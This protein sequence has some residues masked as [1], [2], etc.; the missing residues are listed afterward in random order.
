VKILVAGGA[1][2]I[3]SHMTRALLDQGHEA[4][5]LDNLSSGRRDAVPAQVFLKGDLSQR[6]LLDTV[7]STRTF[8]CVLHFASCSPPA[9]TAAEPA[10]YYWNNVAYTLNL[11]D[12]M[13]KRQ[14]RRIVY[15]SSA[16]VY[17]EPRYVPVEETHPKNPL[18]PHGRSRWMVEQVL[19]DYERAHGLR[20]VSLRCFNAAGA[21]P[22]GAL[23]GYREP[24]TQLIP[25]AL[26]AAAGRARGVSIFGSDYDTPDGTCIR[27]YV[28]VAD[29][30]HAHLL[31]MEHLMEGG[32]SRA[33]NV[34]SGR[35]HSV[36]DVI[37]CAS[38]VSGTGI[39]VAD[40]GRREGD[41]E[42]LVADISLARRELGWQPQYSEL[43][44]IVTDAWAWQRGGRGERR[45]VAERV[46]H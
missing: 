23:G 8:D 19:A 21:H 28:H 12:A 35:G 41:A 1:G 42:Q 10:L 6:V 13:V 15:S 2:F 25:A 24:D 33:Y 45:R 20:H 29:V 14:V 16:A 17:G 7:L 3:G 46:T 43:E 27:D 32:G 39:A 11:L 31:A 34:G 38:R 22:S 37:A 26:N 18:G 44:A 9:R 30:C 36:R 4:V 5:V 40:T